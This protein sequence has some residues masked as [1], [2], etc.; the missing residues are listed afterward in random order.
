MCLQ[1]QKSVLELQTL[2]EY[3]LKRSDELDKRGRPKVDKS[4]WLR[5]SSKI[6]RL[7]QNFRDARS[8]LHT[9]FACLHLQNG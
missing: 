3:R 8:N 7:K 2:F 5:A 1:V 9:A 6:E 4:E